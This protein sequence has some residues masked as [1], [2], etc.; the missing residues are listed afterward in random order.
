MSFRSATVGRIRDGGRGKH[1][2]GALF[3]DHHGRGV[4]VAGGERGKDRGI[5]HPKTREPV[6]A[7][8][9]IDHGAYRIGPHA[10]GAD[11]MEHRIGAGADVGDEVFI[12]LARGPGL[13]FLGDDRR[14]RWRRSEAAK[15]T[16]AEE[17]L[18]DIVN[19]REIVRI[20]VRRIVGVSRLNPKVA[21][22]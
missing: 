16:G 1:E 21:A 3:A 20:D 5:D 9:G 19:G 14:K 15:E 4:G 10:A 17:Q 7:E 12:A 18:F 13:Q 11:G 6:N 8:L 2:F 22:A